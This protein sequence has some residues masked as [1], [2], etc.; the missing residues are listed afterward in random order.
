[1]SATFS[2]RIS[3]NIIHSEVVVQ[4]Q[5]RIFCV[6]WTKWIHR[7]HRI[8]FLMS[9]HVKTTQT[10][11]PRRKSEGKAWEMCLKSSKTRR[12]MYR[13][14]SIKNTRAGMCSSGSFPR[15]V[16]GKAFCVKKSSS[17]H[18]KKRSKTLYLK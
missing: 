6:H 10:I 3:S 8:F 13:K 9:T 2:T 14:K 16:K 12:K 5:S 18:R 7:V 4:H 11:M 15:C 17:G 1:M